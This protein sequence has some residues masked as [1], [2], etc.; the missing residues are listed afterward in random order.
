MSTVEQ[1]RILPSRLRSPA[2][3]L[4]T[5]LVAAGV[6]A[7]QSSLADAVLR[8]VLVLVLIACALTD[9]ER[10]VIPNRITGP[11]ALLGLVLGLALDPAGEPKRLLWAAIA[12]GFLVIAVL[13]NPAGLGMGDAKLVAV[14]GLYLGAPVVVAL[15]FALLSSLLV[16]VG[17]AFRSGVR[18]ARKTQLPFGPYLAAGGILAALVGN[19]LLHVFTHHH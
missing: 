3:M 15:L 10:R 13:A 9:L 5:A 8:G 19:T 1:Q 6:A 11:A 7:A 2:V 16:G 4:A 14:M 18:T 17:I 12:G